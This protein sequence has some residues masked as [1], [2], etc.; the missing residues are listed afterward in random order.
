M[1]MMM[2]STCPHSG[3]SRRGS[4]GGGGGIQHPPPTPCLAKKKLR[5]KVLDI[6]T[7]APFHSEAPLDTGVWICHYPVI[8]F[9]KFVSP[10]PPPA[11]MI[12]KT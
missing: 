7:T 1:M 2:I 6:F 11:S 8:L 10:F 9:P 5:P 4:L 12:G 3:G